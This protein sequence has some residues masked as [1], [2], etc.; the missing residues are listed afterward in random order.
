M[1][2]V[3]QRRPSEAAGSEMSAADGRL[4]HFG[5]DGEA[6]RPHVHPTWDE[7]EG[8]LRPERPQ[9]VDLEPGVGDG[10][11]DRIDGLLSRL[12]L[13]V[14]GETRTGGSLL[15]RREF[16]RTTFAER[17]VTRLD[18]TVYDDGA[19]G[20]ES[21]VW[22]LMND[23]SVVTCRGERVAGERL[24]ELADGDARG[25]PPWAVALGLLEGVLQR[26]H[27]RLQGVQETLA[28][29]DPLDHRGVRSRALLS[30]VGRVRRDL[31][32]LYRRAYALHL[33]AT[34]LEM[35][36]RS[37]WPEASQSERVALREQTTSLL[38]RIE[39]TRAD[40]AF[41][42]EMHVAMGDFD[43]N[44][45]MK[46]LT[47]VSTAALPL[48]LVT[49]YFGMNFDRRYMPE[50]D[51][52]AWLSGLRWG[53]ALWFLAVVGGALLR[54]SLGGWHPKSWRRRRSGGEGSR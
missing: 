22:L 3:S 43:S 37:E 25:V 23:R 54:S 2:V 34:R 4:W 52:G 27:R 24:S 48:V 26:Q 50:L 7:F 19:S 38:E 41:A 11:R 40:A 6:V 10:W 30:A 42:A 1:S 29:L 47:I 32:Q 20:G 33:V 18:L 17:A 35:C 5:L 28:G 9:W 21:T 31:L 13:D 12:G 44:E 36:R 8:R 15:A 49:A 46:W 39:A 14:G 51:S 16:G 45:A 53:G